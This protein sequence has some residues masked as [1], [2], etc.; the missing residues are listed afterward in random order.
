[1]EIGNIYYDDELNI[2]MI[3]I[4]IDKSTC[5]ALLID[6][7]KTQH[8]KIS[9]AEYPKINLLAAIAHELIVQVGGIY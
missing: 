4:N 8:N 2:Y 1:M 3:I 6:G 7:Y 5:K 9:V